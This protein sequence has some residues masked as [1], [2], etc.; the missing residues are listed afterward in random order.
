MFPYRKA[1]QNL[2]LSV[3]FSGWSDNVFFTFQ[4]MPGFNVY[5]LQVKEVAPAARRRNAKLSFSFVFPDKN[6]RFKVQEVNLLPMLLLLINLLTPMFL[7]VCVFSSYF[8]ILSIIFLHVLVLMSELFTNY[9]CD[10]VCTND[11]SNWFYC[12]AL[13]T[14]FIFECF[15]E[16]LLSN[17]GYS[18]AIQDKVLSNCGYCGVIDVWQQNLN[19][20]LFSTIWD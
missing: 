1:L 6:G 15:Y 7:C 18:S 13:I 11:E 10:F 9:N 17:S 5:F 12:K 3:F 16:A 19:K 8:I 2:P 4:L 14:S 20:K